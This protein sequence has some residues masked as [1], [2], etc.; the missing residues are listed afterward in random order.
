M[1]PYHNHID[2][3]L[4]HLL[5]RGNHQ[6]FEAVYRRYAKDLFGYALRRI[7]V[8]E[9]CEEIVHDIFESLWKRKDQAIITSLRHYLFTSVRYMVIRY[10]SHRGIKQKFADHYRLFEAMY[11]SM[12]EGQQCD[13][14]EIH[15]NILQNIEALPDRC[16][17]A[18]RL[19]LTEN[20]T[21]GQIADRMH[22]SKGTVE[23]YITKAFSHL[24]A[25][26][27]KIYK[28]AD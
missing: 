25:S 26:R 1:N 20:L 14:E 23:L 27:H 17:E 2:A 22:I 21:N 9:D 12:D 10:F 15:E 6:A 19:R 4:V 7:R 11:E 24:R 13:Q 8:R 3:E 5:K 18:I 28:P 16:R